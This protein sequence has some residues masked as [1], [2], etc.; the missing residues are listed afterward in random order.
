MRYAPEFKK[1]P[2]HL[3]KK[4]A[5]CDIALY[6]IC[7]YNI[8]RD[9]C[10]ELGCCFYKG[11]CYEKAVPVY[12]Q[13]FSVLIVIIAGAFIITIIYRVVQ[14][15]RREK[16]VP[17][18]LPLSPKS[19]EKA[20][21]APS[22]EQAASQPAS[23]EPLRKSES[24]REG[25]GKT[26]G[27]PGTGRSLAPPET[28]SGTGTPRGGQGREVRRRPRARAGRHP[29]TESGASW[30]GCG[31]AWPKGFLDN[32]GRGGDR[33]LRARQS[34]SED[35]QRRPPER[36]QPLRA[37]LACGSEDAEWKLPAASC[38]A[39]DCC[40][41]PAKPPRHFSEHRLHLHGL[42]DGT[43]GDLSASVTA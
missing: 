20:E 40:W 28:L 30:R 22:G 36:A 5:V 38:A 8:T 33:G 2:S 16:E 10:K 41:S 43:P 39:C 14:E 6:D 19:S 3:L 31:N 29:Q 15:N 7:D 13:V 4:F 42:A 12:V 26:A 23:M 27:R 11:V 17:T 21:A 9:R 37:D 32:N 25:D 1:S 34:P 35:R 24:V 18:D